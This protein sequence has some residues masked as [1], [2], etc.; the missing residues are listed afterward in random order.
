MTEHEARKHFG[1][2]PNDRICFSGLKETADNARKILQRSKSISERIEAEKDLE[3]C[4]A[5]M[6]DPS[7][8]FV[9]I[10]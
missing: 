4:I 7:W 5:L 9:F 8:K 3:A 6:A 2:R 10:S 1:L